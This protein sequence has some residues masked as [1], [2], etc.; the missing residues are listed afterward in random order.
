M[1]W[2]YGS[3][4]ENRHRTYLNTSSFPIY[5]DDPIVQSC[6]LSASN[7]QE[8]H[9]LVA[10]NKSFEIFSFLIKCSKTWYKKLGECI[11]QFYHSTVKYSYVK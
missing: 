1:S 9:I 4:A 3:V 7:R 2:Y 11:Q 6:I 5:I 10:V 8:D